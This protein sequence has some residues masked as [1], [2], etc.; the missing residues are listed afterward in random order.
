ME[1]KN[2]KKLKVF[3][4]E[5]GILFEALRKDDELFEG[6]FGQIVVS[7]SKTGIIRAWHMHEKQTD[8]VC[9]VKG[10]I[11]FCIA[12][13]KKGKVEVKEHFIGEDNLALIKVPAGLWHGYKVLGKENAIV[14][15]VMDKVYNS[16]KPDEKRKEQNAFGKEAWE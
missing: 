14:L 15:Y 12:E 7:E 1:E 13:E 4:D 3:R 5:R 2:I 9:C 11:K 10:K 8:Y 6:R 16:E